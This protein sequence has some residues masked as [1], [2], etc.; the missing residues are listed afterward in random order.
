MKLYKVVI[1]NEK[2][3]SRLK[4]GFEPMTVA[5]AYTFR[6]AHTPYPWRR[7]VVEP[8]NS[9]SDCKKDQPDYIFQ[10]Y[11]FRC[12]KCPLFCCWSNK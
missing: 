1:I 8:V 4:A 3:G 10:E 9:C 7:M 12:K 5:Q 6:D 2:T 11:S